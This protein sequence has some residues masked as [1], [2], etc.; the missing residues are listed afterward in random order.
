MIYILGS[1]GSGK[2][3]LTK[4][5]SDKLDS[6]SYYERVESMPML[7]EYYSHGEESRKW[8]SFSLQVAFLNYRFNQLRHAIV[9]HNA[10]MDS[11]LLS[12]N[13]MASA[14]H[15]RGEMDDVNYDLYQNLSMNMQS[16]V[17]GHPFHGLPDLIIYLDI[18][19][20]NEIKQIQER[21]RDIE[22]ITKDEGLVE[23]YHSINHAY[24]DWYDGYVQSPVLRV[25]MNKINFVNNEE[26]R[27]KLMKTIGERMLSLGMLNKEEKISFGVGLD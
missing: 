16:E 11:S 3:S 19:P 14:I 5:L 15:K 17:S 27:A 25:D 20:E 23:Y 7:K 26:D 13:I 6:T 21:G 4:L 2:S 18:S 12:D 22:D 10:V 9:E 24:K 8:W 1:I